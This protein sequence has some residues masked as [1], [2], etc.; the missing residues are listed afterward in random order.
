MSGGEEQPSEAEAGSEEQARVDAVGPW[1][2]GGLMVL[3]V[4]VSALIAFL[5]TNGH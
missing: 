1:I 5:S 2:G 3:I 4:V